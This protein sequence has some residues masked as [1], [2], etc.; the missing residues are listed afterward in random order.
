MK[1]IIKV[2]K[3]WGYS[4]KIEDNGEIIAEYT[5]GDSRLD[6]QVYGTGELS[7]EIL[8]KYAK[9]TAGEMI[10]DILVNDLR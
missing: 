5:A 2:K 1:A 6:S 7:K 4:V 3:G 8:T 9:Q 10:A